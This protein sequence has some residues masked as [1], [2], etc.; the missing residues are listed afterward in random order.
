MKIPAIIWLMLGVLLSGASWYLGEEF[1]LFF[2][3]G[4]II[5][6]LGIFKLIL[7]YI[8]SEKTSTKEKQMIKKQENY[9][10]CRYCNNLTRKIDYYCSMC[11]RRLK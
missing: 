4:M 10:R 5:T 11:G 2:Y 8:F 9:E 6:A 3:A 1:I 7:Q